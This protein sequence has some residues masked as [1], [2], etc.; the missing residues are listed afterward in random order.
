MLVARDLVSSHPSLG[1]CELLHLACCAAWREADPDLRPGAECGVRVWVRAG[2]P[3]PRPAEGAAELADSRPF[4]R[5][6]CPNLEVAAGCRAVGDRGRHELPGPSS[7]APGDRTL[8]DAYGRE[9]TDREP[10]RRR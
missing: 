2:S 5:A 6:D 4:R 1:A 7:P 3:D 10:A 8:G 9:L